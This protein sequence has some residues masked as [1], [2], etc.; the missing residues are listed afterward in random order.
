[1][2]QHNHFSQ[3][4]YELVIQNLFLENHIILTQTMGMG[5]SLNPM[6]IIPLPYVM[7]KIQQVNNFLKGK[8]KL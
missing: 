2:V 3:R 8:K 4:V 7:S 6:H 5:W 1:M